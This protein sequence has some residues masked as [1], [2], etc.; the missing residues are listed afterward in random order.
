M[1]KAATIECRLA[2]G[3]NDRLPALAADKC[4]LGSFPLR[5]RIKQFFPGGRSRPILSHSQTI[6]ESLGID[7]NVRASASH[8]LISAISA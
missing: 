8:T 7:E 6:P 4:W 1:S 2:D 5:R 3:N